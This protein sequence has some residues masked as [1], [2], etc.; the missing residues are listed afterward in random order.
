MLTFFKLIK[1]ISLCTQGQHSQNEKRE[2]EILSRQDTDATYI[3][4]YTQ[5]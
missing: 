5:L 3:V 4:S 2:L 1:A